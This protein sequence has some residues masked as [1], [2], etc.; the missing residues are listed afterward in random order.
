[1]R[2]LLSLLC[3]LALCAGVRSAF[4]KEPE[5]TVNVGWAE[6]AEEANGWRVES[7]HEMGNWDVGLERGDLILEI[8][9]QDA[10]KVGPLSLA[11]L[12]MDAVA[13]KIR[14][15]ALRGPAKKELDVAAHSERP[16]APSQERYGVGLQ[17]TKQSG[18][19]P[20]IGGLA[21]GGPGEKAGLKAGDELE[22]VDGQDVT[23][24]SGGQVVGL[25]ISSK[26][27]P[28]R[29]RIRRGMDEFETTV[30]RARMTQLYKPPEPAAKKLPIYGRDEH[31]P[32]FSLPDTQNK[33]VTLEEF[34][35][36]WVLVNFWATWCGPCW[37]EMPV[38][39]KLGRDLEKKLVVLGLDVDDDPK[40][41]AR[42]LARH[43]LAYPVLAG[44]KLE[45]PVARSYD[46]Q[47][48]PLN[49]L[50][51]PDG[52]VRYVELGFL[53][54]SPLDSIVRRLVR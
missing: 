37:L 50:I 39:E 4:C 32:G 21:Q 26:P 18:S 42:F 33:M 35:G 17:I 20:I 24:L 22:A 51:E 43:T 8:E 7:I 36:H 27:A 12:L 52:T 47:A 6:V 45:G 48:L 34:R 46:V 5:V 38:L 2:P 29:L 54:L 31:A 3:F 23:K 49:V 9:G 28:V 16:S 10:S 14:V 44:G 13:L 11:G 41:F 25:L 19:F 30:Q 1:M 40:E 15:T 53:P